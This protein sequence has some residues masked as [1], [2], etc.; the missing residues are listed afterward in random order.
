MGVP[1]AGVVVGTAIPATPPAVVTA[2]RE[3][4]GTNG[5]LAAAPRDAGAPARLAIELPA[6]ASLYVDGVAVPGTGTSRQFHTP[7]LARGKVYFYE[8][9]V[10]VLIDGKSE[11]EEKKIVVR[12]GDSAIESFPKLIALARGTPPTVVATK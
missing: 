10:V 6:K 5:L 2:S 1:V 3:E 4:P 8:L 7:E 11:V 9:K 12:A